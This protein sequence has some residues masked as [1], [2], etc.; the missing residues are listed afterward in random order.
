MNS[1]TRRAVLAGVPATVAVASVPA[2][3]DPEDMAAATREPLLEMEGEYRRLI[4]EWSFWLDEEDRLFKKG[5]RSEGLLARDVGDKAADRAHDVAELICTTRAIS[6]DGL[7]VQARFLADDLEAGERLDGLD[8]TLARTL[9]AGL[10]G[11]G[12][13]SAA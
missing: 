2:M 4:A 5:Q 10:M 9:V 8:V 6:I 7:I 1:L 13:R 3:A 12:G 11:M